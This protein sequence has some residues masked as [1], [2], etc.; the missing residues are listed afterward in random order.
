MHER[1]GNSERPVVR[2]R[3][4]QCPVG[5]GMDTMGLSLMGLVDRAVNDVCLCEVLLVLVRP[6]KS[7]LSVSRHAE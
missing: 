1:L 3:I 7:C 4:A 6:R 5:L 2:F